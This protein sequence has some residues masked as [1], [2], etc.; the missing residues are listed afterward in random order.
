MEVGV[1][2]GSQARLGISAEHSSEWG[3]DTDQ[4][5]SWTTMSIGMSSVAFQKY[6]ERLQGG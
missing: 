4:D 5:A 6:L 2:V 1:G 3:W